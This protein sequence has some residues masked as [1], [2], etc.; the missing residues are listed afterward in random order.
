MTRIL[1]IGAHGKIARLAIPKLAEAGYEVAGIVRNPEHE[2]EVRRLGAEPIVAD[3]QA[4]DETELAERMVG[5]DVVV[6]SAGAGGGDPERTYA[7]DRDAAI[8][9]FDAANHAGARRYVMVSYLGAGPEHGVDPESFFFPYAEAKTAADAALRESGL[10]W[11][12]LMPTTLSDE[13]GAGVIAAGEAAEQG[14]RI[15]REDVA[16]AI[17]ET[18]G[19]DDTIHRD[20]PMSAGETPIADAVSE[21]LA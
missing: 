4:L 11:T 3:V 20:L 15:S 21:A 6:W 13:P 19:R 1:L 17:V 2:E 8:R 5:C 18:V 14:A 12:I 7:V 16:S 10:D 9:S